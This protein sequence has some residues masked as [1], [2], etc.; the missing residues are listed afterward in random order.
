MLSWLFFLINPLAWPLGFQC[1]V[2][3]GALIALSFYIPIFKQVMRYAGIALLV[4]GA[5][6]Q[7]GSAD[8][9]AKHD[10]ANLRAENAVLIARLQTLEN[11]S[12][13]DATRAQADA[14]RNR[15]PEG[16]DQ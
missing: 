4:M 5:A 9:A 7:K 3:G 13:A 6:Y 12:Q 11:L 1:L 2:I 15:T 16:A 10:A 8:C 14:S